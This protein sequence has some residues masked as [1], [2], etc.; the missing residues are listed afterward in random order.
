MK[1]DSFAEEDP[2]D[3]GTPATCVAV[4]RNWAGRDSLGLGC[5]DQELANI[6]VELESDLEE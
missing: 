4:E 2:L 6:W 3:A 1:T 5:S